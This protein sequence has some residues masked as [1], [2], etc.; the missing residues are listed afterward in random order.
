MKRVILAII[1][2]LPVLSV[3]GQEYATLTFQE[4]FQVPDVQ[5]RYI[6]LRYREW[7]ERSGNAFSLQNRPTSSSESGAVFQCTNSGCTRFQ[8]RFRMIPRDVL[9]SFEVFVEC[10]DNQLQLRLTNILWVANASM[11]YFCGENGRLYLDLYPR[12]DRQ[13]AQKIADETAA[14]FEDM[15]TSVAEGLSHPSEFEPPLL[16]AASGK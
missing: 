9:T 8:F 12:R 13:F 16:N 7:L 3:R 15:C 4:T 1:L 2:L 5:S 10:R 14:Y 11:G 6:Y